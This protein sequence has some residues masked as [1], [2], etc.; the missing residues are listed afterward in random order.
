MVIT[1]HVKKSFWNPVEVNATYEPDQYESENF[2]T[3]SD[4]ERAEVHRF[5]RKCLATF[6]TGV[7]EIHTVSFQNR[8]ALQSRL[9]AVTI[10]SDFPPA[11]ESS[12][13]H[14][15]PTSSAKR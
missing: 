15:L 14:L 5:L 11:V 1:N 7:R 2:K 12:A 8:P 10:Q 6:S 13:S 9:M 4:V 3:V